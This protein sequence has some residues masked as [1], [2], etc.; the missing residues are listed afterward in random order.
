MSILI[1]IFLLENEYIINYDLSQFTLVFEQIFDIYKMHHSNHYHIQD[2][3]LQLLTNLGCFDD[4]ED[5]VFKFCLN[6]KI[7][8]NINIINQEF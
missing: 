4:I 3:L 1:N 6:K 7:Y 2:S 8:I 5:I